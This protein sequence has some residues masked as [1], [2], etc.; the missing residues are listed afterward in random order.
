VQAL[1]PLL[2]RPRLASMYETR[3]RDLLD[4]P[5]F[6]N[7]VVE[8]TTEL[9]PHELLSA[10]LEIERTLGRNRSNEREKGPRT[11]DI[12]ILLYGNELIES[13]V[14]TVPH[15][16]IAERKFVLIPLL[17]LEPELRHPGTQVTFQSDLDSL[18]SQGI[19][20]F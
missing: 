1:S 5:L 17:E 13:A 10:V 20:Y 9:A 19:Y 14:L 15:P 18:Q 7:T 12:D 2:E 3:P 4:Q 16:R 11:I 6:L 8:G